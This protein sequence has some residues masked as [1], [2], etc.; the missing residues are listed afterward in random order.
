MSSSPSRQITSEARPAQER[1]IAGFPI[2]RLYADA[3][4]VMKSITAHPA[5][6][7]VTYATDTKRDLSPT[8][9]TPIGAVNGVADR[10]RNLSLA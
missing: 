8:P 2:A 9:Q 4:E 6:R 5:P 3:S 7:H 10:S 1:N